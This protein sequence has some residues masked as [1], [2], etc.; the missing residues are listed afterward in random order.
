VD[1]DADVCS[2]RFVIAGEV[3]WFVVVVV[4]WWRVCSRACVCI[5]EPMFPLGCGSP[6]RV[7]V[8]CDILVEA[9]AI[10]VGAQRPC[11]VD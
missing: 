5:V 4:I 6:E 11:C 1:L 3:G 7:V 10:R 2:F 9:L 8:G